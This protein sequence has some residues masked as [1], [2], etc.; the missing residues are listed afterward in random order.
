MT[1]R[2]T[3]GDAERL[4]VRIS[5][6]K[7]ERQILELLTYLPLASAHVL[8]PFTR[9]GSTLYRA[10][11]N[12]RDLDLVAAIHPSSRPGHAPGLWC[13]TDLGLAVVAL[14]LETT[15]QQ[16]ARAH[17]LRGVDLL[18]LFPALPQV[19]A[20]YDLLAG[21]ASSYPRRPHLLAW[22]RPWRRRYWLS[23]AKAPARISVPAARLADPFSLNQ[24]YPIITFV[25]ASTRY[26]PH[27]VAS[28]SVR[29]SFDSSA[30]PSARMSGAYPAAIGSSQCRRRPTTSVGE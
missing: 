17:G 29:L 7:N 1:E 4:A 8:A 19:L 10:L 14:H 20:A 2:W 6:R 24:P 21:L 26:E 13:L 28:N 3:W 23:G 12:L 22:E 18:C 15:P 9:S 5:E 16:L 27:T 25:I 11:G 30:T